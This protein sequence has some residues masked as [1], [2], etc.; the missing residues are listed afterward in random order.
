MVVDPLNAPDQLFED[1]EVIDLCKSFI[2]IHRA[3][4]TLAHFLG[5]VEGTAN[6]DSNILR[7]DFQLWGIRSVFEGFLIDQNLKL[8]RIT[9]IYKAET[10]KLAQKTNA[11][12]QE[13]TI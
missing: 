9:E 1:T 6:G 2:D 8:A 12:T 11:S 7:N 13:A 10:D 4:K 5:G 3:L